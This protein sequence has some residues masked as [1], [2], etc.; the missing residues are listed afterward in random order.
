MAIL[1][2]DKEYEFSVNEVLD[3]SGQT[4]DD[5]SRDMI[6]RIKDHLIGW[7]NH[8][9][10][11]DQSSGYVSSTWEVGYADNWPDYSALLWNSSGNS[12]AWCV[13]NSP[14][15]GQM[16]IDCNGASTR[17]DLMTIKW[18][19]ESLFGAG[20]AAYAP[21]ASDEM[22]C[23]TTGVKWKPWS[24]VATFQLHMI[25]ATDGSGDH[26]FFT[27][28]GVPFVYW[29]RHEVESPVDNY[30]LPEIFTAILTD[31]QTASAMTYSR[32][33]EQLYWKGKRS[34]SGDGTGIFTCGLTDA[35][36]RY[37]TG[38]DC[39][40]IVTGVNE[41]S[42][43]YMLYPLAV[44]SGSAGSLGRHGY[45]SD[46]WMVPST[47]TTGTT[48]EQDPMSPTYEIAV[49]QNMALPWNGTVPVVS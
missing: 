16:L 19:P 33:T 15:Y 21:T 14:M 44:F 22:T 35:I 34:A 47:L 48:I 42:T 1:T 12:H 7:T 32:H 24:A 17:T 20:T 43:T 5:Q 10:S 38:E 9:W 4:E 36:S 3:G 30:T 26:A 18:S 28:N 39:G 29:G 40:Q 49:F 23:F 37:A 25:H 45:V 46:H 11:V 13:L 8:P 6:F 41:L 31:S 2:F 27:G